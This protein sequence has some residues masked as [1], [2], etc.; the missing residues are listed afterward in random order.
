M[1]LYLLTRR[2]S[3]EQFVATGAWFFFVVNLAKIPVYVAHGLISA[4]SLI[5]DAILAPV[6]ICGCLTGLWVIHRIPQRVFD[7][8]IMTLTAGSVVLL[9]WGR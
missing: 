7:L 6:V 4:R 3:K 8:L 2:L 1:S 9:F 5:F